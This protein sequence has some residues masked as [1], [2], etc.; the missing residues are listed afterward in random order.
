M[1]ASPNSK[2]I[3]EYARLRPLYQGFTSQLEALVR[4][5]ASIRGIKIHVIE[6]RTKEVESLSE[7]IQRPGKHYSG[8]LDDLPDLAG[9]RVIVYYTDDVERVGIAIRD[10]FHVHEDVTAH[11]LEQ[12][13]ADRFE[14]LSSH[15]VIGLN[16]KR[17]EL[18]EWSAFKGLRAEI[19]VRTVLQ[20]SWA[21]IS[22][23]L[24]YKRENDVPFGMQ[25]KLFRLAGIFELADEEFIGLRDAQIDIRAAAKD[26]IATDTS[27]V[28]I[29][30]ET[31]REFLRQWKGLSA[32]RRY[33]TQQGYTFESD[34]EAGESEMQE[35][36]GE[37]ASH[38]SRLG[39]KT[40]SE[41]EKL[42][43]FDP[44]S[45]FKEIN[46][47]FEGWQVNDSFLLLLL[48]VRARISDFDAAR[49]MK[50]GWHRENAEQVINGARRD[51]Q[52]T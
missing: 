20:H 28:L 35:Y 17:F 31:V 39:I 9:I 16:A 48:L 21:A 43:E 24:Q 34:S 2:F 36:F 40:V 44:R 13:P 38:C 18:P 45:Y 1:K 11:K 6:S 3:E 51:A 49:L 29:D 25:R 46:T 47:E 52:K 4:Q 30:S 50:A 5:I 22:H 10:E 8:S 7:K 26:A 12:H 19:Q 42:V 33:A 14:Y 37:I 15:F 27:R 23:A 32:L 41:L